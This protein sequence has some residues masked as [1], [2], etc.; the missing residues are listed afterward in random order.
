MSWRSDWANEWDVQ[1]NV[2]YLILNWTGDITMSADK[3][4]KAICIKSELSIFIY[5]MP[6]R[7]KECTFDTTN[8]LRERDAHI[9]I[10]IVCMSTCCSGRFFCF[11]LDSPFDLFQLSA[12]YIH[13]CH[14]RL[15]RFNERQFESNGM[16]NRMESQFYRI[17]LDWPFDFSH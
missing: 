13:V 8:C 6:S 14:T 1:E 17:W 3:W 5:W 11:A 16:W 2:E 12:E 7:W 4:G 9:H 15:R 10:H